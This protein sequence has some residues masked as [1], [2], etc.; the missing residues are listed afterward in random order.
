MLTVGV[1]ADRAD[2]GDLAGLF[3]AAQKAPGQGAANSSLTAATDAV[4]RKPGPPM[5][6]DFPDTV[7]PQLQ[8]AR[9][10]NGMPV[11][12]ATR[13]G[14]PVARVSLAIWQVMFAWTASMAQ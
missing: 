11:I 12:I 4:D 8:R 2:V 7:F 14:V 1:R 13:P 5:T 10:S 3:A 6:S 9:L